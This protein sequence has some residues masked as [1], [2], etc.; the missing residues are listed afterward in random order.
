MINEVLPSGSIFIKGSCIL[1][2][3]VDNIS[4]INSKIKYDAGKKTLRKY[5]LKNM[6][7]II[8]GSQM[9]TE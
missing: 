9:S 8:C 1:A 4:Y 2:R 3:S 7:K 5:F 6:I